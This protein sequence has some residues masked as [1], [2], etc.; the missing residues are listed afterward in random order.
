MLWIITALLTAFF[1]ANTSFF[2]KR[3]MKK[4]S[5]WLASW[6]LFAFS[7]PFFLVALLIVG[8]PAI[9]PLFPWVFVVNIALYIISIVIYM[10]AIEKSPLSLTLPMVAFTPAFMLLTGPLIL[11]EFPRMPGL[12]GI[13][14]IIAGAYVLNAKDAKKGLL[15]P[16]VSLV[17]ERGPM[18][19][20][21]VAVMW[22]LTATLGKLLVEQSSP[23]FSMTSQYAAATAIFSLIVFATK[24]VRPS[25]IRKNFKGLAGIGVFMSLSELSLAY[26][27][28]LTLA[29]YAI[30]VKRLSILIG[31]LYGFKFFKEGDVVQRLA[32]SALMLLGIVLI[33][34]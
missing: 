25:D 31:S 17:R 7:L 28:T 12:I 19:M 4:V 18:L 33:A 26:T 10:R 24:K 3:A 6:A 13:A 29:V 27:Y 5:P 15:A 23:V 34:L 1:D 16:F 30:A 14:S 32:G 22:S 9:G 2:S 11:G 21:I 8:I 20:F